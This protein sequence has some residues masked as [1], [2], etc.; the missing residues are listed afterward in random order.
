MPES[1]TG[2][3]G[4]TAGPASL[5]IQAAAPEFSVIVAPDHTGGRIVPV[6]EFRPRDRRPGPS[7]RSIL[8][9]DA[10]AWIAFAAGAVLGWLPSVVSPEGDAL[11]APII[12]LIM[13]AV[14]WAL[15]R[16]R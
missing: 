4:E 5:W 9:D 1:K 7:R 14:Y 15:S 2:V 3:E 12:L 8:S 6:Y 10:K 11:P 13:G 16:L